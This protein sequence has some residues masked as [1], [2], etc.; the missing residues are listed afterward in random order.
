MV[1]ETIRYIDELHKAL[2]VKLQSKTGFLSSSSSSSL[3]LCLC[4]VDTVQCAV[5]NLINTDA[6][7]FIMCCG[8]TLCASVKVKQ[9]QHHAVCHNQCT[10]N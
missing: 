7:K 3:H 9:P 6:V 2:A 5:I 10:V 4:D 1:E 8:V